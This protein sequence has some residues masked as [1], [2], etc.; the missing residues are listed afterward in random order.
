MRW[1]STTFVH[2]AWLFTISKESSIGDLS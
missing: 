1:I 2:C